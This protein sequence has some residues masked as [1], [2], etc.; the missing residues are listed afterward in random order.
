MNNIATSALTTSHY[1]IRYV[2]ITDCAVCAAFDPSKA[3]DANKKKTNKYNGIW[4]TG[5]T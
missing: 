3:L 5:A 1:G 2:I 4:A